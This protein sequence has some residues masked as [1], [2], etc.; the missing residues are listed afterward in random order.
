V[1]QIGTGATGFT[2]CIVLLLAVDDKVRVASAGHLQ[3]YLDGEELAFETG[4]PLGIGPDAGLRRIQPYARPRQRSHPA[5]TSMSPLKYQKQL[6]LQEARRVLLSEALD[7][8][9]VSRRVGYESASQFSREY[10]RFFG[11]PRAAMSLQ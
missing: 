7:A 10:R 8:N 3:P 2:T 5:V 4:L 6:R 11:A 1:C 9:T